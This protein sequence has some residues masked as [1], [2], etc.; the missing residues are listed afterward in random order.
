MK[1][2]KLLRIAIGVFFAIAIAV[3]A[4]DVVDSQTK[5]GQDTATEPHV[6]LESLVGRWEGVC[7]TWF[8][9][10]ELADKSKVKGEFRLI[11]DGSLLR[12]TY[13]GTLQGNPRT[14]EETIA[15]NSVEKKFQVSWIDDFH[16]NYYGI[17]FS[18]G[19]RTPTGFVVAGKY[20]AGPGQPDWGWRTV[21][22][23]TDKDH[24]TITAY[25]VLPDGREAKAVETKYTRKEP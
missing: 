14:G 5:T 15:F 23:L 11:L 12:H 20:S 10:G 19:D 1:T 2:F 22:E 18:E 4:Q 25:N 13:E 3:F 8:R 6:F 24:L 21:F 9:P 16:M 7:R 17:L